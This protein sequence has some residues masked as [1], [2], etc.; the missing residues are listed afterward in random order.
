MSNTTLPTTS[1]RGQIVE[2]AAWIAR[3]AAR[4]ATAVKTS[5]GH[6]ELHE[7][8]QTVATINQ[9]LHLLG[10]TLA[11]LGHDPAAVP[12]RI[13]RSNGYYVEAVES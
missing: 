13:T 6:T 11:Y 12:A 7:I 1:A 8:T 5:N 9:E 4:L 10:L 2:Q 3:E